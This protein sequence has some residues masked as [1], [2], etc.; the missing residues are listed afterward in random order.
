MT[1]PDALAGAYLAGELRVLAEQLR[2]WHP[3]HGADKC[4]HCSIA[5]R[6]DTALHRYEQRPQPY[7]ITRSHPWPHTRPA[8]RQPV[9]DQPAGRDENRSA[10]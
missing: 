9:R 5:D 1:T 2:I 8:T 4:H 10:P 6:L 3:E 7:P